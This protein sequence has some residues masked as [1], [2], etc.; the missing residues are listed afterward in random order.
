MGGPARCELNTGYTQTAGALRLGGTSNVQID[1]PVHSLNGP[2]QI[3]GGRLEGGGTITGTVECG[4][5]IAPFTSFQQF[6][7]LRINWDAHH[8]RRGDAGDAVGRGR[9]LRPKD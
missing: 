3:Q 9:L 1:T 2:V 5:V 7:Q 4:G 6:S 8:V